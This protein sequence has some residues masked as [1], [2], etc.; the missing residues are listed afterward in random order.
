MKNKDILISV[1]IPVYNA[2]QHLERCLQ[3]V[4]KQTYSNL[5][6]ILVDDGS[7]DRSGEICD[8]FGRRDNRIIVVH[9]KNGG[10]AQARNKGLDIAKGDYI[11]FIDDDDV[12]DSRMYELLLLNALK[13]NVEISGCSTM[14]VYQN[15]DKVN[16]F[17]KIE[18]GIKNGRDLILNVLY[19][20][21]L[22]WGTV[23]NKIFNIRL[24]DDLYFPEASC[25]L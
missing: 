1:I 21:Q 24:K 9:K 4:L 7:T 23:W 15:G 8:E 3:S 20:N 2:E 16:S 11:G 10:Q 6:I 14:M 13:E 18:S 25:I 19:Q 5:E 12:V 17:E 22:S